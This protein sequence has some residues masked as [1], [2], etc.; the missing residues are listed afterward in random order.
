MHAYYV[1]IGLFA[2]AIAQYSR[3]QIMNKFFYTETLSPQTAKQ[4]K[5]IGV[6]DLFMV[7]AMIYRGIL[8]AADNDRYYLDLDRKYEIEKSKEKYLIVVIAIAAIFLTII[9]GMLIFR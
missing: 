3:N 6:T 1:G 8:K 7:K 5:D 9:T 2:M 4:F